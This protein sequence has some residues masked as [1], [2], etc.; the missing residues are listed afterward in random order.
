MLD[1]ERVVEFPR[2]ADLHRRLHG[3]ARDWQFRDAARLLRRLSDG[4]IEHVGR[5]RNAQIQRSDA[6][7]LAKNQR[8]RFAPPKLG[9]IGHRLLYLFVTQTGP[10]M[11]LIWKLRL[12]R[13]RGA[14]RKQP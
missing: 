9:R 6:R 1:S 2:P 4:V 14:K 7:G 13:L 12:V 11:D 8:L 5:F 3:P 10:A